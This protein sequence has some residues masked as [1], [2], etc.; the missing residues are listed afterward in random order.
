MKPL[1]LDLIPRRRVRLAVWLMLLV[2]AVLSLDGLSRAAELRDRLD[3]AAQPL[4][5]GRLSAAAQ[6]RL[7]PALARE[8][9]AAEQVVQ[10]LALPWDD[11]FRTVESAAYERVALL[12]I[13]PDVRKR[14]LSI[15][16][17]AHD[18]LAMLTYVARLSEPG[19]LTDV[20]LVRHE[21]R[22]DDPRR[23]LN[24]TIA[25]SWRVQP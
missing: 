8:L 19:P 25:A 20:H 21:V 7:D 17:E 24:F 13:E 10:R 3:Q 11:L 12:A 2:G 1:D 5:P 23:P 14:E 4:Q 18:F 22:A 16:G 9:L 6:A 15:T